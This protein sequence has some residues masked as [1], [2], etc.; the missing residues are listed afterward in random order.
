MPAPSHVQQLRARLQPS[1][2]GARTLLSVPGCWDAFTALLIASAGFDAAFV[3][4]GGLSLTRL[5]RPDMGLVTATELEQTLSLIRERTS[6]PLIVDADTGFGG[7]LNVQR[8]IRRLERA[9]A[10]A[11]QIEDQ[12]F[13]KRCGHMAG[14]AVVSLEEAGARIRAAL[15]AREHSLIAARTD[16]LGP[17]GFES[18]IER[19]EMFLDSGADLVFIEG[20]RT[21]EQLTAIGT[22]L[23][24]RA[25][26]V[27]NLLDGGIT[28]TTEGAVLEQ[29][30][31]AVALHPLLLLSGLARSSRRWLAHLAAER[32]TSGL[33]PELA[34]LGELNRLCGIE[35]LQADEDRVRPATSSH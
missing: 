12:Q 13:P 15:D 30:G 10:S 28:P 6:L 9:G 3:T 19:A 32:S 7:I 25:P 2:L 27:H 8:T 33:A 21:M 23:G 22:R 5:G 14:K 26:L 1:P 17:E 18:A 31:F 16:A 11:I 35:E 4:G 34:D 24:H 29:L 20:P